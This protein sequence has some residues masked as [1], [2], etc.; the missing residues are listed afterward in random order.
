MSCPTIVHLVDDTTPGGVMRV[1]E[2]I[3][4]HPDMTHAARHEILPVSRGRLTPP[5]LDASMIIS[6]L[7]LSWRALP[8]LMQLR[9]MHAQVPLVH[10]EHSYTAAFVAH[11]V[12]RPKRFFSLLRTAYAL[13]DRVAA[14]STGQ[15]DW[16]TTRALVDPDR[17]VLLRSVVDLRPFLGLAPV[18]HDP[19]V[20]GAI[21]RLDAQKGFDILIQAFHA[22]DRPDLRLEIFG[23]GAERRS[24][25]TL[26]GADPRICFHGHCADPVTAMETV[27]IVAMPSRWEAYGLVGL[28]ARA[29]GRGLWVSG[30]DGLADQVKSG[31]APVGVGVAAWRDALAALGPDSLRTVPEV[32]L[33]A[34]RLPA[35]SIGA[36]RALVADLCDPTASRRAA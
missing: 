27:D 23:E 35:E 7:A 12:A 9:A 32:R 10:V 22:C 11:R 14:V 17:L 31:A 30:V 8:M 6:H 18:R 2:H 33:R 4:S 3:C 26:A 24:L 28:E 19:K 36:W 29:S 25:E 15:R 34:M 16:L 13:F 21:G 1:I 5:S 20:I